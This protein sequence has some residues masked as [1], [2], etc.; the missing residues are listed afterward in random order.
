CWTCIWPPT[1]DRRR[2]GRRH[3]RAQDELH[4]SQGQGPNSLQ[5][6][7]RLQGPP[8]HG[9][10]AAGVHEQSGVRG[11]GTQPRKAGRLPQGDRGPNRP[12]LARWLAG[13]PQKVQDK[14]VKIGLLDGQRVAVGKPLTDH[15]QDWK[16]TLADRNNSPK[17]VRI[18]YKRVRA[19]L[20]GCKF[21]T[22]ADV[23]ASRVESW[24]AQERRADRLP[25]TTSN[26]YLRDA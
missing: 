25:I 5:V 17:H 18:S 6:V 4:G 1:S 8:G 15:L 9:A 11:D 24:L 10:P 12:A 21:S 13:L 23:Q 3:A 14:L 16:Q 7:R 22:L 26:Y 20:D 2:K 19:L